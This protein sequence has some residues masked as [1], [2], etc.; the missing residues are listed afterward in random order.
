[1]RTVGSI[2]ANNLTDD[3]A[4]VLFDI[5]QYEDYGNKVEWIISVA[6]M[7]DN[8]EATNFNLIRDIIGHCRG[9][10]RAELDLFHNLQQRMYARGN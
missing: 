2:L 8:H 4:D 9:N 10:L 5:L 7:K 6:C 1:M 3:E